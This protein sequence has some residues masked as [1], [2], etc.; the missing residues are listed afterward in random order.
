M[1]ELVEIFPFAFGVLLG[2]TWSRFG[3][4]RS[5]RVR[6]GVACMVLGAFATFASGEWRESPLYFL[7]DIALVAVVSVATVLA[8]AYWQ[9]KRGRIL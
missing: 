5:W 7:F 6:W 3:G 1:R 4:P 9:R 2:I 8:I